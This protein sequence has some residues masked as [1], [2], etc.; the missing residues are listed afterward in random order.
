[1]SNIAMAHGINV[2]WV[3]KWRSEHCKALGNSPGPAQAPA[4]L[5]ITLA[6]ATPDRAT[7]TMGAPQ[8]ANSPRRGGCW[9]AASAGHLTLYEP[10]VDPEDLMAHRRVARNR[11]SRPREQHVCLGGVSCLPRTR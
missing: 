6:L 3:F 4:L 1:M 10:T 11:V 9:C 5:P 7:G 2:N 8:A